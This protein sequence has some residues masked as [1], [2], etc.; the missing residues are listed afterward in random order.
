MTDRNKDMFKTSQGKYVAPSAIAATF[1]G[2][3]PYVGELVACGEGRPYCVALVSLDREA[4]T[5]WAG[6]QGMAGMSFAEIAHDERT[7]ALIS[8]YIDEL[9]RHLNRW[10]QMQIKKFAIIDRELSIES[11]DLTRA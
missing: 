2:L 6:K 8:G 4:I 5:G 1:K 9:N 7:R 3:C 10:E 11:G